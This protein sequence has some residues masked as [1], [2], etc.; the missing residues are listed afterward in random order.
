MLGVKKRTL[1]I[2][3]VLQVVALT[4]ISSTASAAP[5]PNASS[6]TNSGSNITTSPVST[7]LSANPGST[8]S[9]TL[10]LQNNGAKPVNIS[11]KL[12]EFKAN[13]TDGSA[14]IYIPPPGDVT[15]SWVHFSQTSFVAQPGVWNQVT[16]TINV[17][18]TAG[19]GYYYAVLFMPGS[20]GS[21]ASTTPIE[22]VKG[23]NAILV[24][25]NV[26]S[27]KEQN[28]L[29]VVSFT[30]SKSFYQYLPASF[31]INIRNNGNIFTS[32]R[33][34]VFISRSP[35]GSTIDTLDINPGGGNILPQTNRVF[36]VQWT[37]GFPV[38]QYKRING[39]IVSDKKAVPIQQLQWDFTKVPK[40]RYGK[41]Y[42]KLVVVYNNGIRDVTVNS[43]VSFWVVPWGL[44]I[45][46]I[47]I[48]LLPATI[49]YLFMR[50]RFKR[51]LAS[52]MRDK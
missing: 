28:S 20:S 6:S 15:T 26:H 8:V 46:V 36:K 14:Q 29:S 1:L 22:K 49:V 39:Q 31:S 40:L 47:V 42:A 13:G 7:T 24:L 16:M 10:Q 34:D 12:Q 17:P 21:N 33:G 43:V 30:S 41:Y 48:L 38:Y 37:N 11:V 52:A 25:L 44:I 27:G 18:P 32:P 23:A 9:T 2:G 5:L 3:V 50:W 19:L 51:R 35:N 4:L 45:S